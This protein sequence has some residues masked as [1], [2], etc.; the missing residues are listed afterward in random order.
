MPIQTDVEL[1]SLGTQTV[2]EKD[3]PDTSSDTSVWVR[4]YIDW[5][6]NAQSTIGP[7][8]AGVIREQSRGSVAGGIGLREL[9]TQTP[10]V[11]TPAQ[12]AESEAYTGS[13]T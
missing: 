1:F 10:F 11:K 8:P 4:Q 9:D 3:L 6:E 5:E 13:R 7:R 12:R 2:L